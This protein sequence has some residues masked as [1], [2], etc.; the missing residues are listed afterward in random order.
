MV[1]AIR[2]EEHKPNGE[3]CEIAKNL[4]TFQENSGIHPVHHL[5]RFSVNCTAERGGRE[6]MR[7]R[8]GWEEGE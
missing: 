7:G 6:S 3:M 1:F 8:V 2:R 5:D 4:G